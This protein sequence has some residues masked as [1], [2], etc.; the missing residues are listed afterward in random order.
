M[1]LRAQLTRRDQLRRD[2]D[3][4]SAIIDAA[5]TPV[6]GPIGT[7]PAAALRRRAQLRPLAFAARSC[8]QLRRFNL[9]RSVN[10]GACGQRERPR[11]DSDSDSGAFAKVA[12]DF[13]R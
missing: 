11:R 1:Q 7:G 12:F 3:F 8:W 5:G 10:V 6:C 2:R 9:G 4:A 13:D